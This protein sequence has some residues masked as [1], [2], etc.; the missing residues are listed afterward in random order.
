M[1]LNSDPPVSAFQDFR[2]WA[3]YPGFGYTSKNLPVY[4]KQIADGET[5]AE[6]PQEKCSGVRV[7]GISGLDRRWHE[8]YSGPKV[9]HPRPSIL[10]GKEGRRL[11]CSQTFYS[12]SY[13]ISLDYNST[14]SMA[15]TFTVFLT[16]VPQAIAWDSTKPSNVLWTTRVHYIISHLFCI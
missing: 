15:M 11:R 14:N 1:A 5:E 4:G 3:L 9:R 6:K 8:E 10:I 7:R 16:A 12:I 2:C 13:F